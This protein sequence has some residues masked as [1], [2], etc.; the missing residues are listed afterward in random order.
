MQWRELDSG[1]FH[2]KILDHVKVETVEA[3]Q[4]HRDEIEQL[5]EHLLLFETRRR[6]VVAAILDIHAQEF[7]EALMRVID[8][9]LIRETR[10][11]RH[12]EN[13]GGENGRFRVAQIELFDLTY[14][15][16]VFLYEILFVVVKDET[17]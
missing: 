17:G 11:V 6:R 7:H 9:L 10:I 4:I 16:E 8:G 3:P 2:F 1:I 15:V 14:K 12:E 5:L 13:Y